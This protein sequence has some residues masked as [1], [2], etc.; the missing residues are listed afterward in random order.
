MLEIN[1]GRGGMKRLMEE[2]VARHEETTHYSASV[3]IWVGGEEIRK[4]KDSAGFWPSMLEGL[5]EVRLRKEKADCAER[6]VREVTGW[7][8]L[9]EEKTGF[10]EAA[11]QNY[12]VLMEEK[13]AGRT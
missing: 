2:A 8:D 4:A 10:V 13:R 12:E 11:C 5:A 3:G 9:V 6:R 7:N 1:I